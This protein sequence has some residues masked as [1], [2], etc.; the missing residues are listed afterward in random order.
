MAPQHAYLPANTYPHSGLGYNGNFGFH[1]P[2]MT[3]AVYSGYNTPAS[4]F[5]PSSQPFTDFRQPSF[6]FTADSFFPNAFDNSN[7][8]YP[9]YQPSVVDQDF[10]SHCYL[11]ANNM[12]PA[13]YSHFDWNSFA[14]NGFDAVTAPPT[15]E[16]FLPIQQAVPSFE[17]DEA[18]PYHPLEDESETGEILVGMGL[19]DTPEKAPDSDPYLDN[20]RAL[21][22]SQLLGTAYRKPDSPAPTGKG[23]KLEETWNPPASADGEEDDEDDDDQDAEGSEVDETPDD[24]TNLPTQSAPTVYRNQDP[25]GTGNGLEHGRNG[26]L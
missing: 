21:M 9:Q 4:T 22:M 5:S 14:T 10:D 7:N 24:A 3:P 15:P 6:Q 17:V 13:M 25:Q 12:D 1:E 26:W 18:F 19:Y 8:V 11:N 2:T 16:N 20:Y 23:L